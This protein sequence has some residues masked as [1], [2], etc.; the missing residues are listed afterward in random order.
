MVKNFILT[1]LFILGSIA[2]ATSQSDYKLLKKES[3]SSNSILY[4]KE[5]SVDLRAMT[6]GIGIAGNY[7]L[8]KTYYNTRIIQFELVELKHPREYRQSFDFVTTPLGGSPKSFVFGKQN[9]FY[10]LHV[11]YGGKHYFSD[12][13]KD[14]GIAVGM[15]YSVGV[16]MGFLKP[17]YLQLRRFEPNGIRFQLVEEKY[18]DENANV[19]LNQSAIFGGAGFAYGL[20]EIS[21]IPGGQAK[22]GLHLDW[23]TLDEFVKGLEVGMMLDIY[24]KE[25]P[26]MVT[27]DNSAIF[28]NLY[29]SVQF[30][31]RW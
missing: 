18:S 6:N 3:Q 26:I 9:N 24:P 29:L 19:F 30:G 31:K 15:F 23:G 12:K 20:D 8:I 22:V 28:M 7:G 17:Y 27:E 21:L 11:G 2:L 14:K 25:V 1:L 16:S 5:F 13:A 4:N 10:A